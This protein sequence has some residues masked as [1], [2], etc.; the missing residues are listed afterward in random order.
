MGPKL[1]WNLK[2]AWKNKYLFTYRATQAGSEKQ[3]RW[4]FDGLILTTPGQV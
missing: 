4:Y 1:P 2:T 3:F